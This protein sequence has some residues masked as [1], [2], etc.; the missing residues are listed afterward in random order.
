MARQRRR[1]GDAITGWLNLHKPLNMTSTQAVGKSKRV[2]N[3]RKAGHGGTLDPLADG[4]LP[5]ALGEAT[6]TAQWA[7]DCDKEY[8]FTTAWG[9]A[10]STLDREGEVVA[11]S[12]VRPTEAQIRQILPQFLGPQLQVPPKFSALKIAGARAYDLAREGEDFGLAARDVE[13]YE[14]ELIDIPDAH[15]A[16]FRVVSGK[17][18]YVRAMARDLAEKLSTQGHV[19]Q[20]RRTRVGTMRLSDAMQFERLE[21]LADPQ[22]D[23]TA[24]LECL[25]PIQSV[26]LDVPQIELRAQ[27]ADDIRLGRPVVVLPH[28][29]EKWHAQCEQ[30]GADR[31]TL[32]LCNGQAVALGE[33]RAG[34]FHPQRV[35]QIE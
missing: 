21:E 6:K 2:F 20:L 3:A 26:L 34:R 22:A 10:T 23:K 33:I 5:I 27:D 14:T 8:T 29:L 31:L 13:V 7:M 24:L 32:S 1:K 11:S 12:D 35:F 15:H 19:S 4:V 17:G 16:T 30:N 18:F 9:T 28:M 25:Q